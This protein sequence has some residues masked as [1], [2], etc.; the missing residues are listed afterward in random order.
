MVILERV[1][2][3]RWENR[4][5]WSPGPPSV[6]HIV[7]CYDVACLVGPRDLKCLEFEVNSS[8]IE[9]NY[10]NAQPQN[11]LHLPFPSL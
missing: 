1:N 3:L 7:V 9:T 2:K 6:E 4:L 10:L 8:D 11:L 5:I